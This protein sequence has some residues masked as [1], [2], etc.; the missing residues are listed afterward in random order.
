MENDRKAIDHGAIV[1]WPSDGTE[2][3]EPGP[4]DVECLRWSKGSGRQAASQAELNRI[5]EAY[6]PIY[7]RVFGEAFEVRPS[8]LYLALD[9]LPLEGASDEVLRVF[10]ALREQVIEDI[11]ESAWNDLHHA[12]DSD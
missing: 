12:M 8:P 7:L 5:V 4:F 6:T 10:V 9:K 1:E 2:L 11:K 3:V